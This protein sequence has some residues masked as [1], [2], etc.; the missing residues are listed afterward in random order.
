M[1]YMV[2]IGNH[3]Q[4]HTSGGEK[5]PSGAPGQGFHPYWGNFGDDSGGECGVPMYNRFHMPDN[6]NHVWWYSFDYGMVHMIVISSEHDYQPGTRQ[7]EWLE[8]DLKSVDRTKTPW[9]MIGAHRAMYSSQKISSDLRTS[10][11][12][13]MAFEDLLYKY[14]VDIAYWAH[15]HSYERTCKVYRQECRNDGILHL[16]V[17]SAGAGVDTEDYYG[18]PWSVYHENDYGYGR[19]TV[20]NSTSLMFE[21]IRNKDNVVRDHVWLHK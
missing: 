8:K 2:S 3:E 20:A 19:V 16:I 21:W 7:Y 4:D 15:Y 5:D 10:F 12:M 6:G 14:H 17:G 9:V 11:G 13:Q 18:M 1:P